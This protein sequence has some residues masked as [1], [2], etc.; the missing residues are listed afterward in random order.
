MKSTC[1]SHPREEAMIIIRQWQIDLTGCRCAAALLSFFEYWHNIKLG[2][3]PKARWANQ[4]AERGGDT[5]DQDT[6]L[7]QFHNSKEL[8]DGIMGL[9][10]EDKIRDAIRRLVGLGYVSVHR[11]P[12]PK[13]SFDATKFFL[14]HPDVVQEQIDIRSGDELDRESDHPCPENPVPSPENPGRCTENPGSLT[15]TTSETSSKKGEKKTPTPPMSH[16]SLEEM[17]AYCQEKGIPNSDARALFYKWEE[18]GWTIQGKPMKSWHLTLLSWKNSGYLPSQ[19]LPS[20]NRFNGSAVQPA[21]PST[22]GWNND[23]HKVTDYGPP[24][25]TPAKP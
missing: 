21:E 9:F 16:P 5:G 19:K 15:K 12:N 8:S 11:N 22:A 18:N 10:G 13:Y 20:G 14:F 23:D 4:T 1:I 2:M 6:S 17:E 25:S 3:A 7:Y 24:K